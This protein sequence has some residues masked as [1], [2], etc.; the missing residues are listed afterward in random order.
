MYKVYTWRF[1]R[2]LSSQKRTSRGINK[3]KQI[4]AI[5]FSCIISKYYFFT[6][7]RGPPVGRHPSDKHA[8]LKALLFL[9][10]ELWFVFSSN[11]QGFPSTR[12][13][14]F[15]SFTFWY[16]SFPLRQGSGSALCSQYAAAN[17][18]HN[19]KQ[20]TYNYSKRKQFAT[21]IMG[22]IMIPRNTYNALLLKL[23]YNS[24]WTAFGFVFI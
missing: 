8:K 1:F 20:I 14:L 19:A 10:G 23:T 7:V 3:W 17:R 18:E 22:R 11:P 16:L 4:P 6:S 12:C 21:E 15:A 24:S 5:V 13:P 9:T 2:G